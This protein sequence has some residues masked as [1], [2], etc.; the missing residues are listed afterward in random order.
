M[1]KISI[2]AVAVLLTVSILFASIFGLFLPIRTTSIP[3]LPPSGNGDT[4]SEPSDE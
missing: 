4:S 3:V 1:R 2:Q